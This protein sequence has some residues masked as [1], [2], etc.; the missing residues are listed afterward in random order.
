[1]NFLKKTAVSV[2]THL[3]RNFFKLPTDEI[4]RDVSELMGMLEAVIAECP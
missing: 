1:E 4:P 3:Y 2:Q